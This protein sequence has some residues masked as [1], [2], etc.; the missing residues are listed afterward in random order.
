MQRLAVPPPPPFLHRGWDKLDVIVWY[1]LVNISHP[2]DT[3]VGIMSLGRKRGR[4]QPMAHTKIPGA[5]P[6]RPAGP[7]R[8]AP[9]ALIFM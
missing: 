3:V 7:Y 1:W 2:L 8:S 9:L 4:R 6:S 5:T